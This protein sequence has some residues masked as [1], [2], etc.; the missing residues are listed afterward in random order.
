MDL[1]QSP[2]AYNYHNGL[3]R[4]GELP[5]GTWCA[6]YFEDRSTQEEVVTY[7]TAGIGRT[8]N[9]ATERLKKILDFSRACNMN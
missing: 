9:A 3:I 2:A 5:D 7:K 1:G 4:V 8:K 6:T